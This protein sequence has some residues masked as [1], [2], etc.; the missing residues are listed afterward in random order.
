MNLFK[1]STTFGGNLFTP[2][3]IDSQRRTT[4][5]RDRT[6]LIHI[7]NILLYNT[8]IQSVSGFRLSLGKRSKMIIFRPLLTNFEAF[9]GRVDINKK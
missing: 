9:I 7:I 2:K 6:R 8:H 4:V 3:L 5:D 1:Y